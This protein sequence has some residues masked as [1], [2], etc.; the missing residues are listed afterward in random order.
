MMSKTTIE[1]EN[2]SDNRKWI[3]SSSALLVGN[4]DK[5]TTSGSRRRCQCKKGQMTAT[6]VMAMIDCKICEEISTD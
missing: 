2:D 4:E 1:D 3:T 6:T 5:E